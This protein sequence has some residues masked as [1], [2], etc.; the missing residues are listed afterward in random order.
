MAAT[1]LRQR[2]ASSAAGPATYTGSR[3]GAS[4]R[5]GQE[6]GAG[7]N[8]IVYAVSRQ[9]ELV[10]KLHRGTLSHNDVEKLDVLVR[11]ATPEL[12]AVA[13]WPVDSLKDHQGQFVGYVMPRRGRLRA[14]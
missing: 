13:A 3:G 4:Y 6:I 8:G 7:G 2:A 11:S 9:P 5:M 10:A 12:L 1:V 14:K